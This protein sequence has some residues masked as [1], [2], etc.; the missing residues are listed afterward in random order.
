MSIGLS[1]STMFRIQ[2]SCFTKSRNLCVCVCG[3]QYHL[4]NRN[5]KQT[6]KSG[7]RCLWTSTTTRLQKKYCRNLPFHKYWTLQNN[8]VNPTTMA[9]H[10]FKQL[11]HECLPIYPLPSN[12]QMCTS[13]CSFR[14]LAVHSTI[15]NEVSVQYG[16]P[17]ECY[18]EV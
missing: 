7:S 8:D 2:C 14:G 13:L 6:S 10:G 11:L 15:L 3:C 1:D 5:E 16:L 17:L 12:M 18:V 9:R 4:S